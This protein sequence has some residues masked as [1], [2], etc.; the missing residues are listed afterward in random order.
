MNNDSKPYASLIDIIEPQAPEMVFDWLAWLLGV[1]VL[2]LILWLVKRLVHLWQPLRWW[3]WLAAQRK[4]LARLHRQSDNQALQSSALQ[5]WLWS[6]ASQLAEFQKIDG[7]L[8]EEAMQAVRQWQYLAYQS[9]HVSRETTQNAREQ[10]LLQLQK[11]ASA[12]LQSKF[13]GRKPRCKP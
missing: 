5:L 13:L 3:L 11:H 12:N 7:L 9:V 1:V 10:C 2:V 4:T 8:S 6:S